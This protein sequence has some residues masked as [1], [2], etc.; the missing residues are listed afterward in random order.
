[1]KGGNKRSY[2][3][4]ELRYNAEKDYFECEYSRITFRYR[5]YDKSKKRHLD[6]Q[7]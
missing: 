4:E 3:K 2:K 5:T 6:L 7:G 1:M